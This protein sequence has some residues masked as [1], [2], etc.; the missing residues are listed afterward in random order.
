MTTTYF[1]VRHATHE[2]V[3]SVLCGRMPEVSLGPVGKVQAA[4]LADRLARE[5][6]ACIL[7][8]PLERARE[9]AEPIASRLG[10]PV[11]VCEAITEIDFGAW[12][13]RSFQSLDADEHWRSWNN[14]RSTSRPPEGEAMLGAQVRIVTAMEDLRMRYP[15][16]PVVLVS[17]CDVI[18][19]ALLYHLGLP[20][21]S[22]HRFEIDPASISTL[23]V[24][25][26]GAKI[27][28]LNEVGSP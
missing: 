17:H 20:I 27:L 5:N 21:D 23:V 10:Q 9:T 24:G 14:S 28:A 13:G 25:E 12:T 6:I 16:H 7:S 3:G 18:K 22:Y 8:S 11:E 4:R 26:W 19:A 1:L 2:R 15:G